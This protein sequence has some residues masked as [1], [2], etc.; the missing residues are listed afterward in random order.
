M[1]GKREEKPECLCVRV[2][3]VTLKLK[4]FISSATDVQTS[5]RVVRYC[6]AFVVYL[7]QYHLYFFTLKL[8]NKSTSELFLVILLAVDGD[9]SG[10]GQWAVLRRNNPH[11]SSAVEVSRF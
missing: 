9:W 5:L 4:D 10:E 11:K 2:L 6:L 3:L 1:K 8:S 7:R